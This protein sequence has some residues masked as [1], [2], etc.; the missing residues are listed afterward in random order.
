MHSYFSHIFLKT[1]GG[2]VRW[3]AGE[4]I[5]V[6]P[7]DGSLIP[8]TRPPVLAGEGRLLHDPTLVVCMR[9]CLCVHVRVC[10]QTYK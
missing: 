2:P 5:G 10:V 7:D 3:L 6:S 8:G 1:S 4:T 9:A